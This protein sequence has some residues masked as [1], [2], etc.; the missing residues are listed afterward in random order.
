[1]SPE[2]LALAAE[3]VIRAALREDMPFGDVSCDAVVDGPRRAQVRLIAKQ[4]GVICGID[5][6]ERTFQ[7]LDA[8]AFFAADVQE[9]DEVR[10]GQ[11]LGAVEGDVRALLSAERVALNFLQRMSGIAT[12]ARAM[13]ALLDGTGIRLVDTRK[14]TPGLRVFEKEAVRVG[15]A[16]NH[17]FCLSDGVMLKDNHLDA[18]GGIMAAVAAARER[19]PFVRKVEVEVE[20]LEQVAEAVEAGA[21]IVMLDNMDRDAMAAAVRLIDGRAEVEVSGNVDERR[22][23]ELVDLGVDYVSSGALT[24]SSPILDLSLKH[25]RYL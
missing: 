13:A 18:A 24:H 3:P 15:G 25:L 5:V 21:D 12:H 19:A 22:V 9:G 7:L 11:D 16:G 23:A 20:T 10:C 2:N 6:F 1:M 8:S 17:R 4:D 14:T